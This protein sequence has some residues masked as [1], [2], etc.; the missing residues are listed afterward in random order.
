MH[1]QLNTANMNQ[2]RL[3]LISGYVKKQAGM[4]ST[5]ELNVIQFA[6]WDVTDDKDSFDVTTKD[7]LTFNLKSWDGTSEETLSL[8]ELKSKVN[9]DRYSMQHTC[10][11]MKEYTDELLFTN[12]AKLIKG[13]PTD[14]VA[15]LSWAHVNQVNLFVRE[16][17]A[18]TSYLIAQ[19][20]RLVEFINNYDILPYKLYVKLNDDGT[21]YSITDDVE[22]N[23]NSYMHLY[24]ILEKLS[25]RFYDAE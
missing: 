4:D 24:F 3:D 12:L 9:E 21:F 7:G 16:Y 17:L 13:V 2:I 10:D 11:A 5:F 22:G 18:D 20:E 19:A 14:E 1:T 25:Y 6:D 15:L 23:W 8:E